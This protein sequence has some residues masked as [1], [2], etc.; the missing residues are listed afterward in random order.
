L[1]RLSFQYFDFVLPAS[2]D[3]ISTFMLGLN[4]QSRLIW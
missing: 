3:S 1:T 4:W 2:Y